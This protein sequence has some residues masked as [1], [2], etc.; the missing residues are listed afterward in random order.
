M[1]TGS[2]G[3]QAR[4][5]TNS[6]RYQPRRR[7][8]WDGL[9]RE[10][11]LKLH[12][13]TRTPS[14]VVLELLIHLFNK[15]HTSRDKEVS[16]KTREERAQ[17]L[18]RFFRDLQSKGGFPTLPDPRNLG[19]R[20]IQAMVAV[21][22]EEK[23]APPTIQT[24]LSFLRGFA[25]WIGKRGLIRRPQ[26]YGLRPDQYT[27][28]S[29]AASDKSWSAKQIDITTLLAKIGIYDPRIGSMLRLMYAFGLR[30]K[31]AIML[32]PHVSLWTFE[33]TGLLSDKKAD[34]YLRVKPGSKGGRERFIALDTPERL[35]SIDYAK[36]VVSSSDGHLGDPARTLKQNMVRF[37]NVMKKF[38]VTKKRLGVTSHGLRHE[39]LIAQYEK[40][41]GQAPPVRSGTR[42]PR[43]IDTI[44]RQECAA[45]AGHAR[46]RAAASYLGG[47]RKR[48]SDANSQD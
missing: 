31:E 7:P 43:E 45:L 5:R 14:L 13:P 21:W 20:H 3:R 32:R 33:A 47:V 34:Y 40:V 2:P 23:L 18:R 42:P 39:A 11:I 22:Q 1:S 24:Y 19:Q 15:E 30:K 48:R 46:P 37:D 17:F 16:F 6:L 28:H 8:E 38:G 10:Q 36:S 25:R 9:T 26:T 35:A 12:P 4:R 27:R 44:A 41:A 29:A